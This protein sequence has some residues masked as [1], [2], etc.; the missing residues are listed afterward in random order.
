VYI[1]VPDSLSHDVHVNS[2]WVFKPW[3]LLL[4]FMNELFTVLNPI[5][6][7]WGYITSMRSPRRSA[8]SLRISSQTWENVWSLMMLEWSQ[9]V[10][11]GLGGFHTSLMPWSGVRR[12][13]E[14]LC[15]FLEVHA[16][17]W[18]RH[19]GCLLLWVHCFWV[20]IGEPKY[21][22]MQVLRQNNA[23]RNGPMSLTCNM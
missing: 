5:T 2:L 4:I 15:H 1:F 14:I 23:A 20:F 19:L 16:K 6:T 18:G 9:S 17:W 22:S 3:L 13:S 21:S 8:Q 12:P 7:V 10:L 11:V